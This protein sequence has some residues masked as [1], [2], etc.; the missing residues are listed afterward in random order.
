MRNRLLYIAAAVGL[1]RRRRA[2]DRSRT[3]AQRVVRVVVM[4]VLAAVVLRVGFGALV[5][6][7]GVAWLATALLGVVGAVVLLRRWRRT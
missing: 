1:T 3:I 5:R 6:I 4:V 2:P 7:G